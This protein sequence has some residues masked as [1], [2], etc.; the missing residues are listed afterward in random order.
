MGSLT[1]FER[2]FLA[3]LLVGE[4]HFGV[5]GGTPQFV[6]GMSIRHAVLLQ[7]VQ[8][9]L[10]G[11]RLYGPYHHNGRF[12]LRLM[13]RGDALRSCVDVFD[14]LQLD[15]WCPHVAG[16]YEVMRAATMRARTRRSRTV[17]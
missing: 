7:H 16:R 2:G 12:F 14:S 15:R 11:S 9:L 5:T 10:P 8:D 13:L 1:D 4:G 17:S 6:L 3:G